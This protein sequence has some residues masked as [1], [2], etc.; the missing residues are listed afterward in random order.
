MSADPASLPDELARSLIAYAAQLR[1]HS[2]SDAEVIG[3]LRARRPPGPRAG[4]LRELYRL[5]ASIGIDLCILLGERLKATETWITGHWL[6]VFVPDF[7][8]SDLSS[9]LRFSGEVMIGLDEGGHCDGR[10]E[11]ECAFDEGR[12]RLQSYSLCFLGSEIAPELF[13]LEAGPPPGEF[14]YLF[15][16]TRSEQG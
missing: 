2:V 16:W 7:S 13:G 3:W 5:R 4:L 10:L 11:G 9:P 14:V 12:G 6:D 8:G 1:R 15:T